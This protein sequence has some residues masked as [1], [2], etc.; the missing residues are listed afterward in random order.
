MRDKLTDGKPAIIS[1]QGYESK[2]DKK[3]DNLEV[4]IIREAPIQAI[5]KQ[6][7]LNIQAWRAPQEWIHTRCVESYE[8]DE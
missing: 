7:C 2:H 4:S 8:L 1:K 5:I 6:T 3:R